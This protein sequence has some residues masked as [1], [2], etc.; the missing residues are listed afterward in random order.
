MIRL[1]DTPTF[2]STGLGAPQVSAKAAAAPARALGTIAGAIGQASDGFVKLG[3]DLARIDNAR[4]ISEARTNRATAYSQFQIELQ[5][6]TDPQARLDRTNAFLAE[7]K[8]SMIPAGAP[9]VVRDAL[10][11]DF[12]DFSARTQINAAQDAAQLT[13]KRATLAFQNE[14]DAA[15]RT[16]NRDQYEKAKATASE[17]LG[18]LP[19]ELDAMDADFDRNT[20]LLG[21]DTRISQDPRAVLAETE[22]ESFDTDHPFLDATDK[23]RIR[24][25]AQSQLED[26]RSEEIDLLENAL[27]D[28]TLA[29]PDLEAAEFISPKDRRSFSDALIKSQGEEPISKQ[30]Y[31]NAWKVT[32]V[33]R[34]ARNNPAVSDD[35]YRLIHNEARTDILARVPPSLQGD[36]KKELGYLSP[37]GR[38]TSAPANPSDR[39]ELESIARAQ[40]TRA[41][42]AGAFGDVSKEAPYE[43]REKAARQAEDIRI[44]AKR[45]IAS[46]PTPPSPAEVR[47]FVDSMIQ[48]GIGSNSLLLPTIPQKFSIGDDIDSLLETPPIQPLDGLAPGTPGSTD[49]FL[50]PR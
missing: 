8:S 12:E 42:D 15:K 19:E 29:P 47:D 32:D 10:A 34:S 5:K 26:F 2:A 49:A 23:N 27:A 13:T 4:M 22:S 20:T 31:L 11:Y 1:P 18:L 24:R 16:G 45:F 28:G 7:Q 46:R 6:E 48:R 40:S 25:A 36:L 50:P 30:D 38:D 35:Q 33:L 44:E 17:A 9:P 14:V 21:F 37:A 39:S 41:H 3:H 43:T